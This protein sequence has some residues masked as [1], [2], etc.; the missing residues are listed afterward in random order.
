MRLNAR[1]RFSSVRLNP[2][3]SRQCRAEKRVEGRYDGGANLPAHHYH[4]TLITEEIGL[5]FYRAGN[6]DY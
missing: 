1:N 6:L 5:K 4:V 2:D 3:R